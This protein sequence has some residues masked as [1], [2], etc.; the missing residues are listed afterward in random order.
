MISEVY[1][2]THVYTYLLLAHFEKKLTVIYLLIHIP[3]YLTLGMKIIRRSD[4]FFEIHIQ[5][6]TIFLD[7]L[8]FWDSCIL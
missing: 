1:P 7:L 8:N 5:A 4:S 3:T 6:N 2:L